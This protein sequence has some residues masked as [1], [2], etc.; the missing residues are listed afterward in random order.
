MAFGTDHNE[1][2]MLVIMFMSHGEQDV[3]W[4]R[5]AHFK[6]DAL[7]ESFQADQCKSLAGKPKIFFIQV[8]FDNNFWKDFSLCCLKHMICFVAI[9]LFVFEQACRGEGLDSGVTLVRSH[10]SDEIDSGRLAYK[11]PTTADFL[12][13]WST[14]PGKPSNTRNNSNTT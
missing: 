2:D 4:G 12:I 9:Y 8:K 1:C 10:P 11:I 6:P 5:D 7:F 3:L 14:V 13:C